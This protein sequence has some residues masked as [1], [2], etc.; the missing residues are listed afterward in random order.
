MSGDSYTWADL[1]DGRRVV[2]ATVTP[3]GALCISADAL[4][5]LGWTANTLTGEVVLRNGDRRPCVATESTS[6][7]CVAV[8]VEIGQWAGARFEARLL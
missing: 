6:G 5:N 3:A 7:L 4:R 1:P 8:A 2:I